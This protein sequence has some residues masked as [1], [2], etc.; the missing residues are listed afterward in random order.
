MELGTVSQT[1]EMHFD[2]VISLVV[3]ASE[4][5]NRLCKICIL[6]DSFIDSIHYKKRIRYLFIAK[7]TFFDLIGNFE[8]SSD[9][10]FATRMGL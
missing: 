8:V 5:T 3:T 1:V 10:Y 6:K 7:S 2:Q 9:K 4:S